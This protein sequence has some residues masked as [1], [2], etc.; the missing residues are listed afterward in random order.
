MFWREFHW[1]QGTLVTSPGSLL[2]NGGRRE[3]GN[4]RRKS[5]RLLPPCSGSTNQIAERNHMYT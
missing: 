5:C 4:I 3:P 1:A 2:K